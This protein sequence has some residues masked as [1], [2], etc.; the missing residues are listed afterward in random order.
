[1]ICLISFA[2]LTSSTF[3]NAFFSKQTFGFGWAICFECLIAEPMLCFILTISGTNG[4]WNFSERVNSI[5]G[6]NIL[7][8]DGETIW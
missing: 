8:V 5:D 6:L 7:S 3:F 1:M 2:P 4:D